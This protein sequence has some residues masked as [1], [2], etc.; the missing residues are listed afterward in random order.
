VT[1]IPTISGR[2][3]RRSA[4]R[5]RS[6]PLPAILLFAAL[7]VLHTPHPAPA[8]TPGAAGDPVLTLSLEEALARAERGNRS[9]RSSRN[10]ESSAEWDLRAARGGLLPSLS[11]SFGLSW[12]GSGQQRFGGLTGGDLGIGRTPSYY[13]S[14]YN[15]GFNFGLS[16]TSLLA[17]RRAGAN[18][19]AARA[20]IGSAEAALR[21]DV[22][23]AYLDVL[24]SDEGVRL[25]RSELSRAEANLELAAARTAVGAATALEER[26]AEVA[27]GR[28]RV[29]L[30][31]EEGDA[32]STRIRLFQLMGEEAGGRELQLTSR[33]SLGPVTVGEDE[34]YALSLEMNPDLAALEAQEEAAAVGLRSARSTYLPSLNIQGGWSG[35]TRQASDDQFLVAQAQQAAEGQIAQCQFQNDLFSRLADP[36]PPIDCGAFEFGPAERDAV[37]A[38]NRAFP[39]DFSRQPPGVSMSLSLPIFQ[40]FQRQQQVESARVARSNARLQVEDRRLALRSE[41][42]RGLVTLQTAFQAARLEETNVEVAEDQ[43]FLAQ[44]QFREGLVDFIQLADAEAVKARADR[45][46]LAAVYAYHEARAALE[47][48][49]G[50]PIRE[51]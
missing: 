42:A 5:A 17:P 35:F 11:S 40:G 48:A 36:F 47:A 13:F 37:L 39:F 34:L 25:A 51:P 38:S 3:G 43:L 46:Y 31:R 23:R 15:L 44:E 29:N 21:L 2:P 28:A 16:G 18:L 12:E 41:I 8:Q 1:L 20:R 50:V 7:G 9:L 19:E 14:S 24:R 33:F 49:V 10:E 22:T 6:F 32:R 45:E 27:V 30:V 4:L 26:Q